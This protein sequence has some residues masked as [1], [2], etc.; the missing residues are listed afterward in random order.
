MDD[1][2]TVALRG[3]FRSI[4]VILDYWG[5]SSIFGQYL[6]IYGFN[7]LLQIKFKKR[8]RSEEK[9]T[10]QIKQKHEPKYCKTT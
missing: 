1:L 10:K 8:R 5:L 7:G 9:V 2:Q 4:Q 3:S 6:K